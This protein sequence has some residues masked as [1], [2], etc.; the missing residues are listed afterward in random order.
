MGQTVENTGWRGEATGQWRAMDQ[1]AVGSGGREEMEQ[2][3]VR[4]GWREEME[5]A[6]VYDKG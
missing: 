5:Q 2:S 1:A 4:S 6:A 3:A